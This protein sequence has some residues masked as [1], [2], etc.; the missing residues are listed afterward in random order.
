MLQSVD[1]GR[2]VKMGFWKR[3]PWLIT[4]TF[5]TTLIAVATSQYCTKD[6]HDCKITNIYVKGN[7]N[8]VNYYLL[9]L[10]VVLYIIKYSSFICI[11]HCH[12]IFDF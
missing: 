3:E 12:F 6:D 1:G 11:L 9:I 10:L 4:L 8:F 7:S 2:S 5:L